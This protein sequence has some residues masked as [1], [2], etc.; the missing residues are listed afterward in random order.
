MREAWQQNSTATLGKSFEVTGTIMAGSG[1]NHITS[2]ASRE[3]S[4]L[5][6]DEFIIVCG[7]ANDINKNESKT[8]LRNIRKFAQQN[9]HTNVIIISPPHRHDLPDSCIN[10]EIHV[11]NRRFHKVLKDMN[12]VTIIDANYTRAEDVT[13][14]GLHLNSAGKEKLI[15][16]IGQVI[17]NSLATQTSS[18]SQNWKEASSA[19][20]NREATV[21]AITEYA[22]VEHKNAVRASNRAKKIPAARSEYFLW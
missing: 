14:H 21:E 11:Y 3:I 13:R 6:R 15:G 18:I 5:Q 1:L 4:Q 7:G 16:T 2:L 20:P 12:H 19:T 17:K 10:G 22:E 8:G 9:K